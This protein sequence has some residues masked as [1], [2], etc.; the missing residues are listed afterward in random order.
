MEV[1]R[2]DYRFD[3]IDL[4][5]NA[6]GWRY[7]PGISL[8][9]TAFIQG[10]LRLGVLDFQPHTSGRTGYDGTVGDAALS[11]GFGRRMRM[12]LSAERDVVFA[13]FGDNLYFVSKSTGLEASTAV[14]NRFRIE[15]GGSLRRNKFPVPVVSGDFTGR[16]RDE[17]RSV[18]IGGSYQLTGAPRVGLSLQYRE[19]DSNFE[20]A[21]WD[22]FRVL[23]NATYTF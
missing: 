19:L 1:S 14:S 4:G 20:D 10:K 16:R 2:E 23:G 11:K 13:I 18:R 9:H 3:D 6:R 8:D 22:E 5:R 17:I 7:L 12:T 15:V 21:N